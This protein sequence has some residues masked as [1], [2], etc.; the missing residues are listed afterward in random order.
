MKK[1]DL[2]D[3][4]TEESLIDFKKILRKVLKREMSDHNILMMKFNSLVQDN[5]MQVINHYENILN[6]SE[7]TVEEII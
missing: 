7:S 1:F 5:Y 2:V 3:E 6:I 4:A